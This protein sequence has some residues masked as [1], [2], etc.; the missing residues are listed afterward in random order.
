MNTRQSGFSDT[1]SSAVDSV[2]KDDKQQVSSTQDSK[3]EIS[4]LTTK[5]TDTV[6]TDNDNVKKTINNAASAQM[7]D[8][9]DKSS[10]LPSKLE[11]IP[12]LDEAPPAPPPVR[13]DHEHPHDPAASQL[14]LLGPPP[15][16]GGLLPTPVFHGQPWA[17]LQNQTGLL[18][19]KVSKGLLP[20]PGTLQKLFSNERDID[21]AKKGH[22]QLGVSRKEEA[23]NN[24]NS[25][26]MDMEMSSPEGDI[27]DKLN[28][29]FWKQQQQNNESSK[30]Q[31]MQEE[32]RQVFVD[33]AITGQSSIEDP[34]EPESGFIINDEYEEDLNSITDPKERKRRK[35]EQQKEKTKVQV[36]FTGR[37]LSC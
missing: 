1:Q 2:V 15:A 37:I 8:E 30:G 18:G 29:E 24:F 13:R 27:I 34:Y 17:G 33:S 31:R 23:R 20:T 21:K 7:L 16:Q 36:G 4:V 25:S 6:K 3:T 26:P 9:S 14:G 12:F 11:T 32:P 5:N 28:E 19:S 22:P 35:K 10:F